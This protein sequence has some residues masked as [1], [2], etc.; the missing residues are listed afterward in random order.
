MYKQSPAVNAQGKR[1]DPSHE[2]FAVCDKPLIRQDV[3]DCHAHFACRVLGS[4]LTW[5]LIVGFLVAGNLI[6]SIRVYDSSAASTY[7]FQDSIGMGNTTLLSA[8]EKAKIQKDEWLGN[9][10]AIMAK[11]HKLSESHP[12]KELIVDKAARTL[13]HVIEKELQTILVMPFVSWG[14]YGTFRPLFPAEL[15]IPNIKGDQSYHGKPPV[16]E[17][18]E[19]NLIVLAHQVQ[20]PSRRNYSIPHWEHRAVIDKAKNIGIYLMGD[21]LNWGSSFVNDFQNGTSS[22]FSFV[23]RDYFFDALKNAEH[24]KV[25]QL[26]TMSCKTRRLACSV[27]PRDVVF[28]NMLL[29]GV[30]LAMRPATVAKASERKRRCYWAGSDRNDRS[31]MVNYFNKS[32][33]CEVYLTPGF[34]R[35]LNKTVYAAILADS[36]FGLIPCGNSPETH[37]L[38][39]VLMFGGIPAMLDRDARAAHMRSYAEP[40]PVISGRTWKD[41]DK[42][43]KAL[44]NDAVD[45]LQ[46]RVIDWWDRHW[47][48]KHDDL[49]WIIAQAHAVSNGRDLCSSFNTRVEKKWLPWLSLG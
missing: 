35:G 23:I 27:N 48:C 38:A 41:V 24:T 28:A 49:R 18:S 1:N 44:S 11:T 22:P 17:K 13:T 10:E 40:I 16:A 29:P 5:L 7:I 21:E 36:V 14:M 26:G 9:K 45:K 33:S 42:K 32:G 31:E 43:M 15:N 34:N 20:F 2:N 25:L 19:D 4:Q 6:V 8:S 12:W 37:R 39:E 3:K 46:Q 30:S 47:K